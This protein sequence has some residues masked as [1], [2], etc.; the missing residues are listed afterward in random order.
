MITLLLMFFYFLSVSHACDILLNENIGFSTSTKE[1]VFF[2]YKNDGGEDSPPYFNASNC[3]KIA[4]ANKYLMI[5][6]GPQNQELSDRIKAYDIANQY[7]DS[8]CTIKNNPFRSIDDFPSRKKYLDEKWHAIKSCYEI[9]V[10]DEGVET[11]DFPRK[12]PGCEYQITGKNKVTFNGGFCFFK[13]TETSAYNVEFKLKKECLNYEGLKKLNI[14][15]TDF[16]AVLNFYSAGDLS[17]SSLDLTSLA[18]FPVRFTVSPNEKIFSSSDSF[19][20]LSPEFPS[21]FY[22]PDTHLGTPE[23]FLS[24]TGVVKLRLPLWTDNKCLESCYNGYC[25]GLCDYAQ[26]LVGKIKYYDISDNKKIELDPSWYQGGVAFPRYQGEI[27]GTSFE[28]SEE[29]LK[30]GNTYRVVMAFNDPKFDF[31]GLRNEYRTKLGSLNEN[32]GRISQTGIPSIPEIRQVNMTGQLPEMAT[33]GELDFSRK[34]SESFSNLMSSYSNYYDFSYWPPYFNKVCGL[35]KCLPVGPDFL[36]LSQDFKVL[37]LN[38]ETNKFSIEVLKV[39]RQSSLLE[40][41][42]RRNPEMPVIR[43][44][45]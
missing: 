9:Q 30:V 15:V 40:S 13:P 22:L 21:D 10:V 36:V 38:K 29:L 33:I 6:F 1:R 34:L 31:D 5:S 42:E 12:Q 44:Q 35:K 14:K 27:S 28:M 39:T 20:L 17:G 11:I 2:A 45:R 18:S 7:R 4:F 3:S 8:G 24:R 19:N 25:Q 16:Q 23:G 43:C 26:P 41:Y 32:L 37:S